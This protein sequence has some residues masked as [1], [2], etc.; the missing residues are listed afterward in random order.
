MQIGK[1]S[2]EQLSE[3]FFELFE[4]GTF[5]KMDPKRLQ[6]PMEDPSLGRYS[7]ALGI[8]PLL[9]TTGDEHIVVD[10]GLGWGLDHK[11]DYQDTSNIVT[12][13]QIFGIEP[14]QVGHVFFSHLHFDHCAGATYVNNRF[15]TTATFPNATYYVHKKEWEFALS[16]IESGDPVIGADYRLDELYKLVAERRI[17]FIEDEKVELMDGVTLLRTGGHSPGHMVVKV[18]DQ[19]STAY[20]L[21]DLIP[22]EYH[23]NQPSMAQIEHNP[24]ESRK[25]KALIL[26]K[27]CKE[28]AILYFYHSLYKKTGQIA[29][30]EQKNYVLVDV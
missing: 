3:G 11:S 4:D 19:G 24:A 16:Q 7:S 26:R 28:G 6:N 22:T 20:Y 25:A 23:L 10:P 9:I 27:A 29:V 17:Q 8:D 14:E 13:L 12:N 5:Q 1:F 15:E 30:D 21:G 18:A 2:I